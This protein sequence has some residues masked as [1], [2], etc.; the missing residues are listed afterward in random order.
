MHAA[1]DALVLRARRSLASSSRRT[2]SLCS[3]S[4]GG[5]RNVSIGVAE[6]R[7]KALDTG[8]LRSSSGCATDTSRPRDWIW[9]LSTMSFAVA[10]G[11]RRKRSST[12]F[13]YSSS[14]VRVQEEALDG[15]GDLVVLRLRNVTLA[16]DW[17]GVTQPAMSSDLRRLRQMFQ[18]EQLVL[19]HLAWNVVGVIIVGSA[20]IHAD[21][22]A[23]AGFALDSLVEIGA[24]I[25]VVW[26][27][28][29]TAE[30]RERPAMRL[31]GTAFLVLA[32]YIA[33]QAIYTLSHAQGPAASP[34]GIGW[35]AITCV[36]MLALAFGKARTGAALDNPVLQTEGRV[37]LIDAYLA[38]A[39][40]LGLV[41]NAAL[42]QRGVA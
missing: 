14:S 37:T 32:V 25:V 6:N 5:R 24:S 20:A 34:L 4:S 17:L 26:Q 33:A 29:G 2:A 31:I 30:N 38:G 39:V 13:S 22:V 41:L 36:A 27:L 9:R 21:S 23:L 28:K 11:A 16:G 1:S 8:N 15:R 19:E 42:G 3:P 18:D 40:L 35:T 10:A 7:A 12:A